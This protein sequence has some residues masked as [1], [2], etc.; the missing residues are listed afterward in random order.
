MTEPFD[1]AVEDLAA[2]LT[3]APATP[4]ID[5]REPWEYAICALDGSANIPLGELTG[6]LAEIPR[7][8]PVYVLC[9]HGGRSAQA[10]R[11]LRSQ[12]V[13]GAINIAG[14]IDRWAV[15]VA[16]GMARY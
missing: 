6:R 2:R 7:D 3:E 16:P 12:G 5:V 10:V 9:H 11:W 13:A 15:A 14:G 4:V 8:Q 1:I